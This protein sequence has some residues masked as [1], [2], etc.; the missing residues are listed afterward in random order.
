MRVHLQHH[1][2]GLESSSA[3][4]AVPTA[5]CFWGPPAAGGMSVAPWFCQGSPRPGPGDITQPAGGAGEG[6]ARP[7]PLLSE[8]W[9][10]LQFHPRLAGCFLPTKEAAGARAAGGAAARGVR[11]SCLLV[12]V[13]ASLWRSTGVP[14]GVGSV[15]RGHRQPRRLR[16]CACLQVGLCRSAQPC[17][18]VCVRVC[19]CWGAVVLYVTACACIRVASCFCVC[20]CLVQGCGRV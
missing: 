3:R 12:A 20:G 5:P 6:H 17:V 19:V 8:R 9:A 4:R 7:D 11:L 13:C 15:C 2:P 18:C 14:A 16:V 1:P 10:S